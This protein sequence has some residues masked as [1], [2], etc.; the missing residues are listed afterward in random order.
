MNPQF[1]ILQRVVQNGMDKGIGHLS[2]ES[3]TQGGTRIE[4]AGR[5]FLNFGSCSYLGLEHHS[6]LVEGAVQAVRKFG[7]QYSS[8]R[9]F[10][11]ISAYDELESLLSQIFG[12]HAIATPTTSLGHQAAIPALVAPKDVIVL[13]HH[14]HASVQN[15][16]RIAQA[17]GTQVRLLPHNDLACLD[18][19]LAEYGSSGESVWYCVD[20]IYSMYGNG[21]PLQALHER[22]IR[23]PHFRLYVDD[24]HGMSWAGDRGQGYALTQMELHPNMVL[25][26]SLNKAFACAGGALITAREDWHERV[27]QTGGPLLFSG[28]IQPPMLG[29]AIASAKLHLQGALAPLQ[30]KLQENIH[31]TREGLLARD[32]PLVCDS[33]SPIFFVGCGLPAHTYEVLEGMRNEGCYAPPGVFPAV[34]MKRG[35]VRFTVTASHTL[36]EIDRFLDV[37]ATHHPRVMSQH[38]VDR[39]DLN[40]L[41]GTY[42]AQKTPFQA[43]VKHPDTLTAESVDSIEA[44]DSEEWDRLMGRADV[45]SA[46]GLQLQ[47]RLFASEHNQGPSDWVFRYVVVRDGSGQPLLATYLTASLTKADML[48]SAAISERMEVLRSTQSQ[49]GQQKMVMVGS[50]LSEGSL[51]LD[52]DHAQGMEALRLLVKEV[53]GFREAQNA[54]GVMLRGLDG[55]GQTEQVLLDEGWVQTRLPDTH[56]IE[57]ISWKSSAQFLKGLRSRYRYSVRKEVLAY[58]D[59]FQVECGADATEEEIQHWYDLYLQV[60]GRAREINTFDLPKSLFAAL[61]RDPNWDVLR[62][63]LREDGPQG[64]AVA[65]MFSHRNGPRYA[66]KFVGMDYRY[67]GSHKIYKQVLYQTV[68]RAATLGCSEIQLG[69]TATLEKKK[70]GAQVRAQY[71]FVRMEDHFALD[72]LQWAS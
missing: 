33:P 69:L 63:H 16:A 37:M 23:F 68:M 52:R 51:F 42:S 18:R 40:R 6:S 15:A 35:G 12:G 17:G 8:S 7:T 19:M 38:G 72:A 59:L 62:L 1:D 9:A 32:L 49:V 58:E 43:V 70:L 64:P 56:A 71:G 25:A 5:E 44:L 57:D 4:I 3:A 11:R 14:V 48:A 53:E 31:A 21:A 24:A 67:L 41:F 50:L 60:K 26:T 13:D 47:E 34:P 27:L 61:V 45:D 46:Q 28:P 22:L 10:S 20:G 54:D 66:A 39:A 36:E 29:A 2:V 30:A 55:D 65:V